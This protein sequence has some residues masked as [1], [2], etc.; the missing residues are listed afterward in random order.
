MPHTTVELISLH[1]TNQSSVPGPTSPPPTPPYF[2]YVGHS[3]SFRV[4]V[5]KPTSKGGFSGEILIHTSFDSVLHIP[6]YYKTVLGGLKISPQFVN[7]EPTFPYR[8]AKVPMYLTNLYQQPVTVSSV[9]QEPSDARFSFHSL[10]DAEYLQL[11]SKDNVQA[12]TK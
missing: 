2:I 11:N 12:S 4:N 9:R 10:S 1:S 3:A 8:V 6:V 7:F 5:T